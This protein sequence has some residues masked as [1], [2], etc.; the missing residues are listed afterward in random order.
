V[1]HINLNGSCTISK[2]TRLK[3]AGL[4]HSQI[5]KHFAISRLR[6]DQLIEEGQERG[7]SSAAVERRRQ[8]IRASLDLSDL[9]RKLRVDDLF[10]L[11]ELSPMICKRLKESF[12]WGD[13]PALSLRQFMD[14]LL[15]LVDNPKNFYEVL[16]ALRIRL[17]G[18]K[19]Y[20]VMISQLSS[21]ALGDVFR[22][23]WAERV[24]RLKE[25]LMASEGYYKKNS[26]LY[27][28]DTVD[29]EE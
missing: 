12:Q 1:T 20:A 14:V 9:D 3:A 21:L 18:K 26:L 27:R 4:T 7:A 24:R 23:E 17:I 28:F 2:V 25:Y 10:C 19:S 15:P 8:Q 29:G 5:A 16:P 22:R 6:V 13:V 11:L